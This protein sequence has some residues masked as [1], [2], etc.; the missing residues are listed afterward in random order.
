MIVN[1]VEW[2]NKV[3]P[4][5]FG[6]AMMGAFT[7]KI[8]DGNGNKISEYEMIKKN[9]QRTLPL[10]GSDLTEDEL[11]NTELEN[12]TEQVV[13]SLHDA[14]TVEFANN[15]MGLQMVRNK[16]RIPNLKV[17][18]SAKA[19][20][21]TVSDKAHK[22][23]FIGNVNSMYSLSSNDKV[24]ALSPIEDE[25]EIK[26]AVI[27]KGHEVVKQFEISHSMGNAK[28]QMPFE[29]GNRIIKFWVEQGENGQYIYDLPMLQPDAIMILKFILN[30]QALK[31][32]VVTFMSGTRV[33]DNRAWKSTGYSFVLD[34]NDKS[35]LEDAVKQVLK[36]TTSLDTNKT[37]I[38]EYKSSDEGLIIIVY[39]SIED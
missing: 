23:Y 36:Q 7:P 31:N 14:S 1:S 27:E 8:D 11:Y 10:S 4:G 16:Y 18:S 30:D 22:K 28:L 5:D 24:L 29:S 35:A 26:K 12:Q 38:F 19:E 33:N 6:D 3:L 20:N 17:D 39:A 2:L 25:L 9:W 21:E 15:Y 34:C 13:R 32:K 37:P